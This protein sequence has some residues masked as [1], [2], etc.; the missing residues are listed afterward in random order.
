MLWTWITYTH[1]HISIS[2]TEPGGLTT[3]PGS[4]G[5]GGPKSADRSQISTVQVLILGSS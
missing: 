4:R 3:S 2:W 1:T 5:R